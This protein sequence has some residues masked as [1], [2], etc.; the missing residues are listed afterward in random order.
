MGSFGERRR[1]EALRRRRPWNGLHKSR[2]STAI[3]K[4]CGGARRDRQPSRSATV[5]RRSAPVGAD[6][7][8]VSIGVSE[9][10][11]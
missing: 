11:R 2:R 5:F 9:G 1:D 6:A 3:W 4:T 8:C 7:A 10:G